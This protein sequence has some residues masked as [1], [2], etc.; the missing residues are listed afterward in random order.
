MSSIEQLAQRLED[1]FGRPQVQIEVNARVSM[2]GQTVNVWVGD[3]NLF[4][5]PRKKRGTGGENA[6]MLHNCTGQK[7]KAREYPTRWELYSRNDP[8][9]TYNSVFM[10]TW[11]EIFSLI[12]D[13]VAIDPRTN[14]LI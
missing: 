10:W 5:V 3:W 2:K 4:V 9:E 14:V 7:Y 11:D 8:E 12:P 1:L 13:V 6:G